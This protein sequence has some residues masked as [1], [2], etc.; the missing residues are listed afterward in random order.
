MIIRFHK[1]LYVD[2]VIP[3]SVQGATANRAP[4]DIVWELPADINPSK[5][6]TE[7]ENVHAV[8]PTTGRPLFDESGLTVWETTT[9]TDPATGEEIIQ[10][11]TQPVT[12]TYSL[13][14]NPGIFTPADIAEVAISYKV[15][16]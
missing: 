14:D 7:I 11:V 8:D 1:N 6:I 5:T 16:N 10:I 3:T 4:G 9:T 2:C 12:K 13:M 15:V